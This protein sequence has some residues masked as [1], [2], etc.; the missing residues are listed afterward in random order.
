LSKG[1]RESSD[2]DGAGYMDSVGSL[3]VERGVPSSLLD[4][5]AAGEIA[6]MTVL[7]VVER[8]AA[9]VGSVL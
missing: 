8:S 4:F 6:S 3:A 9:D 2:G 5:V 1:G 7:D